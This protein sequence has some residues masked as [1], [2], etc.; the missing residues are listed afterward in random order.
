MNSNWIKT[1]LFKESQ[2]TLQEGQDT[3]DGSK[4]YFVSGNTYPIRSRLGRS[5]LGFRW[6][7]AKGFWWMPA[8]K[9]TPQIIQS[10]SD[11]GVNT[12]AISG[13]NNYS[14]Y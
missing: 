4:I 2:A 12:A 13:R 11:L 1:A 8:F 3:R 14:W 7:K 9:M 5:G 10:L 6:Y